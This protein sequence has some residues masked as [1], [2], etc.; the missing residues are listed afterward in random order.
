MSSNAD[1]PV[2]TKTNHSSFAHA[3][4]SANQRPYIQNA[5]EQLVKLIAR[6]V[7]RHK[8]SY[9]QLRRIFRDVRT[10]CRIEAPSYK[11]KLIEL[12]TNAD[13]ERFFSTISD[14]LHKLLFQVLLGT[15]LR[16]SELC[17]L[18]VARIDFSNN[19][20]FIKGGKDR[21]IVFGNHLKESLKLYLSGRNNRYLFESVNRTKFSSRRIQQIA[22]VYSEKSGVKINPHL[23]RHLF[24]TKLAE[25]GLSEDQRAI[26]CGHSPNSNAQQIYTHLSLAGVKDE[27]I[28]A[29]DNF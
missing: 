23:L 29:L 9:E 10:R 15:G 25:A 27:A 14:P 13:L 1:K 3:K 20:A 19:T 5:N 16:V 7:N 8:L 28:K 22:K 2:L 11:N 18:E 17:S 24:A 26:L 21:V 4:K 12:P 6:E